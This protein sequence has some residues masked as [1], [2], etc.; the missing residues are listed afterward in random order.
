MYFLKIERAEG[1]RNSEKMNLL[2]AFRENNKIKTKYCFKP[3]FNENLGTTP[4]VTES[5]R[6]FSTSITRCEIENI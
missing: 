1:V 5:L 4:T 6:L 2:H 3:S